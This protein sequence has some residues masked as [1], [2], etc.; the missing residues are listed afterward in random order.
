[1]AKG[2]KYRDR[3]ERLV[4]AAQ[5]KRGGCIELLRPISDCNPADLGLTEDYNPLN[6]A[7]LGQM[8]GMTIGDLCDRL[9]IKELYFKTAGSEEGM[10]DMSDVEAVMT[11]RGIVGTCFAYRRIG[12]KTRAM[13]QVCGFV[14]PKQV[15]GEDGEEAAAVV[16][17]WVAKEA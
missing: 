4:N 11:E 8:T 2:K 10:R 9:N 12:E 16:G 7:E 1:M 5:M 15:V 3:S 13:Q 14:E 6:A 17:G